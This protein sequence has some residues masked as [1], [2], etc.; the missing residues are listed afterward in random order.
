MR[1][2]YLLGQR[3]IIHTD[4]RSLKYFLEQKKITPKQQKWLAKL[5]GY[6]Y[7]ICYC[8]GCENAVADAL[9]RW[10][11]S[12]TLNHLFVPQVAI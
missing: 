4:Q 7:K 10:P 12:L 11:D 6:E 9:S 8:P 2:P 5:M 1:R 3:F